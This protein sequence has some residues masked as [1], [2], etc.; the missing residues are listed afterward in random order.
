MP[1][2]KILYPFL[3]T[4]MLFPAAQLK[5]QVNVT[6]SLALVDL[7]NST[8]GNGWTNKTNWLTAQPVSSW[9]GITIASNRVFTIDLRNNN[10][11][12]TLPASIGNLTGLESLQLDQ[13]FIGG[14]IP[15][16]MGNLASL[17][18][19]SIIINQLTGPIPASIGNLSNLV[20]LRLADNQLSGSLPSSLGNLS[21]LAY[22]QLNDNR[23]SGSIPP[24]FGNLSSM[25][26]M[27]L[28]LN[29]LT[30]TIPA[31]LGNLT[32]IRN[33]ELDFNQL[34]GSIPAAIGNLPHLEAFT[35][36]F[37][38]L[39]GTIPVFAAT[40]NFQYLLL[41]NN[42]FTFAG[43]E[44]VAQKI[45]G[46]KQYAPQATIPLH[47]SCGKLSVSAGGTPANNTYRWYDASGTLLATKVADSTFTPAQPGNYYVTVSNSIAVDLKLQSDTS[48]GNVIIK[49]LNA[50]ICGGQFYTLPSGKK[51][52]TTGIY[53][54][55][56]K[57]V[58]GCGDSLIT[59]LNLV[60]NAPSVTNKT[61]AICGGQSYILPSGTQVNSPGIYHD[62]VFSVLGCDSIITALNLFV[63]NP[64]KK[65]TS[66]TLCL[67]QQ[68]RLPSGRLVSLPGIYLD[69][70]RSMQGCDSIITTLTLTIDNSVTQ[71]N[72]SVGICPGT[73]SL[74]LNAGNNGV[75]YLWNTGSHSNSITVSN[76]GL[77]TA[78]VQGANG[79]IAN[80]SFQVLMYSA[81]VISLDKNIVLCS[82]QSAII[83]AGSGYIQYGWNTG[84]SS[85]SISIQT[86][87]KYWVTVTDRYQCSGT[88]TTEITQTTPSP[89]GFLPPDTTVCVYTSFP[90]GPISSFEKY[91]WNTG[92]S[93]A[94]ILISEPGVYHL[95]VTD[96]NGCV[97]S[98]TININ[99]KPCVEEIFVPN[100]FT[101]NGDGRNDVLR[102]LNLNHERLTRF[103]FTIFNRWGQRIFESRNASL[104]WDGKF[105]G[106]ELDTGV[107]V[108]QLEYQFP[109][110]PVTV[111]KGT[112]V[113]VR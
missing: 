42:N 18:Y 79:C 19:L 32:G 44:K 15:N 10:L 78:T 101:P 55:T 89:S 64:V 54:D 92:E 29:Q 16:S 84:S 4:V 65:T 36:D 56:I 21:S 108:W 9:Y 26:E 82:G 66:T 85:Q 97:G 13:N 35:V 81:P 5:G 88:D 77:Y 105:Q 12:G 30:G 99:P 58:S 60:V 33:L 104:G 23:F 70:L 69:T 109:D 17:Q 93:T 83:D 94:F 52:N 48:S 72:D 90:L 51:V 46:Q 37:N 45:V 106:T 39:S 111:R 87:G 2:L 110:G 3:L 47:V 24:S 53:N 49:K 74:Q 11:T 102:P 41:Q 14:G 63:T 59:Q 6:D 107:Y 76:G 43:M 68:Y 40:A 67:G 73:S 57:T 113:L 80:D 112:V 100:G 91:D 98:D 20:W 71:V 8:N 7:Y 75:T 25:Y 61:V 62:T 34:T 1:T 50:A 38:Q 103:H 95:S 96:N 28:S 27:I 22:M 86:L 31:S